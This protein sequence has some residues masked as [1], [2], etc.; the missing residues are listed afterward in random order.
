MERRG[1][2]GISRPRYYYGPRE[3]IRC[4][5][6]QCST[7]YGKW[8][9]AD[10]RE[11]LFNRSYDPIWQRYPDVAVEP[12]DPDEWVPFVKQRWFWLE[13]VAYSFQTRREL[14]VAALSEWGIA[15]PRRFSHYRHAQAT[16][17]I[18]PPPRGIV[19]PLGTPISDQD[20]DWIRRALS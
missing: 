3:P 8:T 4:M 17:R 12:A 7:P 18:K 9:C 16:H 2:Y 10:G 6:L 14:A 20:A 1:S 15:L 13:H 11:V 5:C 19:P